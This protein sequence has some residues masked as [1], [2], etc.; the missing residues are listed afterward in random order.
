MCVC[1][2]VLP[3]K[4]WQH[5]E[6]SNWQRDSYIG[7]LRGTCTEYTLEHERLQ[8]NAIDSLLF[9]WVYHKDVALDP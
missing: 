9:L 1:V 7:T 3:E 2:Q 4:F 6:I 5:D 8:S